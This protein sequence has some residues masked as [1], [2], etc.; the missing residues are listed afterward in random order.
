VLG[1][2]Q[3]G[4]SATFIHQVLDRLT[5]LRSVG[6]NSN[7]DAVAILRERISLDDATFVEL[8]IWKLPEPLSGSAHCF[9][10]RLALIHENACVMRYDNESGKGDHKHLG[11]SE[12]DY[13]FS[14]L[15]QLQADFWSDVERW[16]QT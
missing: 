7:M 6:T 3:V 12:T 1:T 16:R 15:E 13:A 10:Y 14:G 2:E 8:V 5:T 11:E 4:G 9:K